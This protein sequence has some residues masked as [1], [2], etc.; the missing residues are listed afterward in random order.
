MWNDLI[1]ADRSENPTIHSSGPYSI[2]SI[3]GI[4]SFTNRVF[5]ADGSHWVGKFNEEQKNHIRSY[6]LNIRLDSVDTDLLIIFNIPIKLDEQSSSAK[7]PIM[8]PD[9][10]DTMIQTV[11]NSFKIN[12]LSIFQ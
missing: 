11:V 6:M 8:A 4:A 9:A 1:T 12:D 2:E 3:P 10:A 7:K 5:F